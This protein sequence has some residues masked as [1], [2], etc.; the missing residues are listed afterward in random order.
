MPTMTPD[1]PRVKHTRPDVAASTLPPPPPRPD[2]RSARDHDDVVPRPRHDVRARQAQRPP[3]LAAGDG[4]HGFGPS[5]PGVI[6]QLRQVRRP[7]GPVLDQE[8]RQTGGAGE[9][10]RTRS[11]FRVSRIVKPRIY[12]VHGRDFGHFVRH[13]QTRE[14]VVNMR[15]IAW[16]RRSTCSVMSS[17]IPPPPRR[18][19]RAQPR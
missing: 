14:G 5:L 8:R 18:S 17:F 9:L 15:A 16:S 3:G 2:S 19:E 11:R 4:L 12:A 6:A 13:A 1:R 10:W 7:I